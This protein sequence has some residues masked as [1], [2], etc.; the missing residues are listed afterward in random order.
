MDNAVLQ[1]NFFPHYYIETKDVYE[2][3]Y[4]EF[5]PAIPRYVAPPEGAQDEL[6]SKYPLQLIGWHTKRRCHSIYDNNLD[7]HK[8]E[9]QRLWMHPLDA[10]ERGVSEGDLVLVWNDRGATRVPVHLTE[11]IAKS[12]CALPQG[13]WYHPDKHGVD[14]AGSINVL[15]TLKPTPYAKGNP[16]HTNLVQVKKADE[17]NGDYL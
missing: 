17:I 14:T 6:T 11:R 2:T 8:I 3:K 9:P 4:S 13:A 16:Q 10:L 5:F 1:Y 12:V 15:T 7:M